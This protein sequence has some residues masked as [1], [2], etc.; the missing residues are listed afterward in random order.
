[1]VSQLKC[2]ANVEGTE[3]KLCQEESGYTACFTKYDLGD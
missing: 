2:F 1:M 3:M